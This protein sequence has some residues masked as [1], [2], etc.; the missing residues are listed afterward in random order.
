MSHNPDPLV[1]FMLVMAMSLVL[2]AAETTKD[3]RLW[4]IHRQLLL[5][6]PKGSA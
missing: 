3:E 5:A 6:L 4:D 2:K 1:H